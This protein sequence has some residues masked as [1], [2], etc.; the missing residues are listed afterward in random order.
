MASLTDL[1]AL[2]RRGVVEGME[3]ETVP[4][5]RVLLLLSPLFFSPALLVLFLVSGGLVSWDESD[6][7][8]SLSKLAFL[9]VFL[10]G[11]STACGLL[12]GGSTFFKSEAELPESSLAA[13]VGKIGELTIG[14]VVD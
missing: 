12:F 2:R 6:V 4:T 14:G 8:L 13:I 10:V 1:R 3:S 7:G 9:L 11:F 5:T